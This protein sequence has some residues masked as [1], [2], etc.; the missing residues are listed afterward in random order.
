[1]QL[2][3]HKLRKSLWFEA[4]AIMLIVFFCLSALGIINNIASTANNSLIIGTSGHAGYE[5]KIGWS[6]H[7]E[8][9]NFSIE[10]NTIKAIN[11]NL[12]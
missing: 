9:K 7:E 5:D 11:I 4:V 3:Q 10:T 6:F 8:C 12:I 2:I 1:M